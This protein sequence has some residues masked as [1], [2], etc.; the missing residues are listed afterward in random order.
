MFK[1]DNKFSRTEYEKFLL[2]NNITAVN[3]NLFYQMQEKK[4]NCLISLVE[5]YF[6]QIF[7]IEIGL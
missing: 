5:E 1:R 2:K 4:N 3:L 6:L 7:L